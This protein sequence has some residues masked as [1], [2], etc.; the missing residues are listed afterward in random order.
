MEWA[1]LFVW[2]SEL[3]CFHAR[4]QFENEVS[5]ASI[6]AK[7]ARANAQVARQRRGIARRSHATRARAQ[8]ITI[9]AAIQ[10]TT[11]RSP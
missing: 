11:E 5:H 3:I 4:S 6:R 1:R 8:G 10:T 7:Q 9:V 2:L